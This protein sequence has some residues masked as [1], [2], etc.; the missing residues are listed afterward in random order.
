MNGRTAEMVRLYRDERLTLAQIGYRYNLT[1]ERVRQIIT[2]HLSREQRRRT[3]EA[4]TA[5]GI[6]AK[7][8]AHRAEFRTLFYDRNLGPE[9]IAAQ[10]DMGWNTAHRL[11]REI[12][13]HERRAWRS[14]RVA[15]GLGYI[16]TTDEALIGMLRDAS[17]DLGDSFGLVAY[18]R[19][20]K[21]QNRDDLVTGQTIYARFGRSWPAAMAAAGLT[22]YA[23]NRGRRGVSESE[24]LD[25]L[26]ETRDLLGHWP[27]IVEYDALGRAPS[28]VTIRARFGGSWNKAILAANARVSQPVAA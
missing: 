27:T 21:Q 24:A 8:D 23:T 18:D 12:P 4:R 28:N 25:A 10:T 14:R 9:E 3:V 16:R 19:W 22:A 26:I 11:W 6:K 17:L 1:R 15:A 13:D 7:L 20:K 2:P 5:A